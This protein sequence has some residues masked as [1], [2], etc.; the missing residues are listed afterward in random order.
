[1]TV[2]LILVVVVLVIL[3]F[4]GYVAYQLYIGKK[5][6]VTD[7]LLSIQHDFDSIYK[8]QTGQA[9]KRLVLIE[10]Q[11]TL[12][13]YPLGQ[14]SWAKPI[15]NLVFN[16]LILGKIVEENMPTIKKIRNEVEKINLF[17]SGV[18]HGA[19]SVYNESKSYDVGGNNEL[20]HDSQLATIVQGLNE[21]AK[22]EGFIGAYAKYQDNF[23]GKKELSAGAFVGKNI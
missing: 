9:I 22:G 1:M 12:N 19:E 10:A 13:A 17:N 15:F 20:T 3:A 8:S 2:K 6:G 18:V 14:Y 21:K 5:G 11:K 16:R 23:L 7:I 4:V